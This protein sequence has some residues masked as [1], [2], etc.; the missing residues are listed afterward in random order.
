MQIRAEIA[1]KAVLKSL[2]DVV[3]P[4]LDPDNKLAQEQSQLVIGLL[5]LIAARLPLQHRYDADELAR[6]IALAHRLGVDCGQ[7]ADILERARVS[8]AELVS[9]TDALNAAIGARIDAVAEG[10][11][12]AE[13]KAM[14]TAVLASAHEQ[15]LRERSWLLMQGWET[16]PGSVPPIEILLGEPR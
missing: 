4:A 3:L 7:A 2:T 15:H 13:R 8:P 1:L 6:A 5:G 9:A 10:T 12:A 11:S 16:D 14:T